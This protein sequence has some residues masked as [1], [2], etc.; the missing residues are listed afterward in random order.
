[1]T[2]PIPRISFGALG[3]RLNA[4]FAVVLVFISA[5]IF[6]VAYYLVSRAIQEKD[7]EVIRA[8]FEVYRAW[9]REGGLAALNARF[10]QKDD[11]GKESFFVRVVGPQGSVSF[12]SIPRRYSDL[13][14]TQLQRLSQGQARGWLTL[15][16][17]DQRSSWLVA[18]AQLHD[19]NWLEVGKTVEAQSALLEHFRKV[20]VAVIAGSL[21]LGLAGGAW[22]TRRTLSPIRHLIEAVQR[23]I[24]TG[25][26]DQRV[27]VPRSND[28]LTQL[29]RL[30]NTML[31][32]NAALIRGMR[33]ALDNV[34]HDL[35]TPLSRLRGTAEQ[36]LQAPTDLNT[37]RDALADSLEESERLLTM[38]N[39]LMDISEAESGLMKLNPVPL[40]LSDLIRNVVELYEL[41]ADEKHIR[42]TIDVPNDL[43]CRA[44]P[45]RLQQVLGNLLDNAL[46]Y[47]PDGGNVTIAAR[48]VGSE[49]TI[50]V[51]DTGIGI[52]PEEI[53]RIWERLYRGDKSRSQRGLGLGL[54]LV[55][56]IVTSHGG[57]VDVSSTVNQGTTFTVRLPVTSPL[58]QSRRGLRP[59]APS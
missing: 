28:E 18:R 5:A 51:R 24:T 20:F 7:R 42:V 3:L 50:E 45:N 10:A 39:T 56:A 19:G 6:L 25:R 54:S 53:P 2:N 30:F 49:M 22:L 11:S 31:E 27:P 52:P 37:C 57:R 48:A 12:M 34:A 41:V 59:L 46:K 17:R 47:T 14:L 9:Y 36:A 21:I 40:N 4:W 35:R 15:P 8:Q 33:E 44:D 43:V 26:M 16:S 58:D 1:M 23:V 38:L 32:R 29:A 55:K 13:D